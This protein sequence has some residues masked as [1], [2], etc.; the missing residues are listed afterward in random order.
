MA[1]GKCVR[2]RVIESLGMPVVAG[3]EIATTGSRTFHL[4]RINNFRASALFFLAVVSIF[5]KK[6]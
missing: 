6:V 3:V 4:A 2:Q 5:L 1:L